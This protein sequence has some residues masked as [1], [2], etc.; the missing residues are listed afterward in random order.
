[1]LIIRPGPLDFKIGTT[2]ARSRLPVFSADYRI[3]NAYQSLTSCTF[4]L[5][6][7]AYTNIYFE[8]TRLQPGRAY[9]PGA[10]RCSCIDNLV[11][12]FLEVAPRWASWPAL[13]AF[14]EWQ[15]FIGFTS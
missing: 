6:V 12:L 1:V 9:P 11:E 3:V 5:G 13:T 4:S 8:P 10:G 2:S 7:G 15:G 14:P